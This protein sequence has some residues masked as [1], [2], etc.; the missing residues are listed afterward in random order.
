MIRALLFLVC[1]LLVSC[2]REESPTEKPASETSAP[3]PSSQSAKPSTPPP[4]VVGRT[5]ESAAAD[6]SKQRTSIVLLLKDTRIPLQQFQRDGLAMLVGRQKGCELVVHDAV[7]SSTQQVEQFRSAVAAKPSA[8]IVSPIDPP[9]LAALIIEA[10]TAGISV[11]GLDKRMLNEGC[12]SN[13]FSDQR[14]VGRMAAETVLEALKRKAEE[15]GAAETTGRVVQI[16]GAEDS[17]PTNELSEGF[18]DALKKESGVILVHDAPADWKPENASARTTEAFRL[19]RQFDV[20]FAHNDALAMGAAK[21][22]IEAG[23][24]ENIFIIGTDGLTGTKR[25]MELVRMGDIDATIVQPALVDFAL[26]IVLK[27]RDEK[28]FK[29]QPAYEI[30][31]FAV[32]PK[33]VEQALRVGT[34]KFPGL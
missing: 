9:A 29:P 18:L 26:Q 10:K 21:A 12:T 4:L 22:A 19:Q 30:E 34:Y 6:K 27:I 11:I 20:I 17:F 16:R 13:V 32:V 28:D 24:R 14:R 1:I 2:D 5:S 31:P 33:N 25:G 15:E 23:E 3:P 7:G 8:I